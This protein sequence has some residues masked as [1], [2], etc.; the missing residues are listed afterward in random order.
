MTIIKKEPPNNKAGALVALVMSVGL[1][2][3]AVTSPPP[4]KSAMSTDFAIAHKTCA[5]VARILTVP[6]P[7]HPPMLTPTTD[8][9]N[10]SPACEI[11]VNGKIALIIDAGTPPEE[12]RAQ[13]SAH[14]A[15]ALRLAN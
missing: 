12:M 9:R 5:D 13:V 10:G 4:E 8:T 15:P 6:D 1:T 3:A 11:D 14:N 2:T 7:L